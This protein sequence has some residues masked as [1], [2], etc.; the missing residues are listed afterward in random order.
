MVYVVQDPMR[1]NIISAVKYGEI[2]ILLQKGSQIT[3]SAGAVTNQLKKALSNFN[4][5]DYL[6]LIGDPAAIGLAVAVAAHWN[7]G[8]VK[9]LKWDRKEHVYYPVS[10]NI[11]QK[12]GGDDDRF[13]Q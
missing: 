8:R 13:Q 10:I 4:D 7:Q 12:N 11:N 2:K 9:M 5:D 6:L 1:M 3:F